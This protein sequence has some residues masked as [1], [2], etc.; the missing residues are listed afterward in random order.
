MLW[1]V[2]LL[3]WLVPTYSGPL[4]TWFN[5]I[6]VPLAFALFVFGT[7]ATPYVVFQ[8]S[9]NAKVGLRATWQAVKTALPSFAMLLLTML[10]PT[11]IYG[12]VW[13]AL[14]RNPPLEAPLAAA[15]VLFKFILSPCLGGATA[16]AI[17]SV[18]IHQVTGLRAFVNSILIVTNN[19]LQVAALGLLFAVLSL[20]P[21]S[22]LL[23]IQ[24]GPS[25]ASNALTSFQAF[26]AT[27]LS[28]AQYTMW[29]Y[30]QALAYLPVSVV[31][32]AGWVLLYISATRK[33]QYPGIKPQP[34]A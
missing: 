26:S 25:L 32:S 6:T 13:Y 1:V 31:Q 15:V 24:G 9:S 5:C 17:T 18:A 23:A 20:V 3:P 27:G 33:I 7:L 12:A 19:T 11:F 34:A 22:L 8:A 16:L 14:I 28:I 21:Q 30:L 2:V 10:I 4:A 29:H